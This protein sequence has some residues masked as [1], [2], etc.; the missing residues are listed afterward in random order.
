MI[1]HLH[2][3][4]LTHSLFNNYLITSCHHGQWLQPSNYSFTIIIDLQL[5]SSVLS[6][7]HINII[8]KTTFS[9]A[10]IQKHTFSK[11]TWHSFFWS[12]F[13][14]NTKQQIFISLVL[15]KS[16]DF[17]YQ[18]QTLSVIS[19]SP[20]IPVCHLFGK[21]QG[22]ALQWATSALSVWV[23]SEPLTRL[24]WFCIYMPWP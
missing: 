19:I 2:H 11:F 13:W 22:R 12:K 20:N 3:S 24:M 10:I 18:Q 15:V 14:C 4:L 17:C 7:Q 5:I 9:T 23:V 8:Y 16:R 6:F 1:Y 21:C